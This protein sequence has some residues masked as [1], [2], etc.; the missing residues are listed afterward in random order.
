MYVFRNLSSAECNYSNIKREAL[1]LVWSTERAQNFLFGKKFLLKSDYKPL[2]FLFTPRKELPK[3]TLSGILKWAI[4]IMAFDF[5]IIYVKGNTISH[6]DAL[7]RLRFQSEN[8]EE[9][10][11]SED[12]IIRWVETDIPSRKTL[13]R[14][15]Q[16]PILSGILE[17]IRKN[18]WSICTITERP[19]KEARHE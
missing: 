10:E 1:A 8:E 5:D 11:N 13:S 3:I 16:D 14:E 7:S 4:K 17:R 2:E 15:T 6:V 9:H 12:R 18:V 19:F